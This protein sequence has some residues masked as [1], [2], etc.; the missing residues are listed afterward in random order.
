MD[1]TLNNNSATG[2]GA[3]QQLWVQKI[4]SITIE[5]GGS[6]KPFES[7]IGFEVFESR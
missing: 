7:K 4:I 5:C 1:H 6:S 2:A 3:S